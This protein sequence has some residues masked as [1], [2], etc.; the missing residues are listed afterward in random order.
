MELNKLH[1]IKFDTDETIVTATLSSSNELVLLM[2]SGNVVRYTID[3][4][5][6]R[7]LFSVNSSCGYSDGGFDVTAKSTIYTLDEI[8]V[9][10]NDYKRH[11]FIHYPDKYSALHLWREDYHA[12]ISTYPVALFKNESGTP[13]IIFGVAWNHLQIMNLDSRQVLTASKSLITEGAEQR[14]ID[15]YKQYEDNNKLPWPTP[16][17]YFYGKLNISP[18]RK[19]F[20]SAGWAWGSCDSYN[21]YDLDHFINSNRISS[22]LISAGEHENRAVCWMNANTVAVASHSFTEDVEGATAESPCEIHFYK[23]THDKAELE[24]TIQV[25]NLDV[26]HAKMAY[27]KKLDAILV[28]SDKIGL[29]LLSLEGEILFHDHKL[30]VDEYNEETG[31]FLKIESKT[32]Q[33]YEVRK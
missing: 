22:I 1:E 18:D 19:M 23:I 11:G 20:L 13:H 27:D 16:Y 7:D 24:K 3:E 21:A 14:H 9:V 12:D 4:K 17:D 26:V 15:F 32:V 10:V 5:S 30:K 25:M 31:L 29:A 28:H 6:G 2:S 8:V 33:V